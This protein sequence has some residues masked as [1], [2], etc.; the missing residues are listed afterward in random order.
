MSALQNRAPDPQGPIV[1]VALALI[2]FTATVA[3]VVLMRELMVVFHG[4]ELSL[5]LMLA[6]WLVWTAAGSGLLGKLRQGTKQPTRLVAALEA[7]LSV[8]FPS[9]VA[10]TRFSRQVFQ[11]VTG[12]MLGPAQMMAAAF[13][14]LA[15]FCLLSGWLFAAGSRMRMQVAGEDRA[16][17][18]SRVYLLEAAGSAAGGLAASLALIRWLDSL[19]V[20]WLLAALNLLVAARLAFGRSLVLVAAGLLLAPAWIGTRILETVSLRALWRGLTVLETRNSVYGNLTVVETEGGRTLYET[21][22]AAGTVPD[23]AAAEEAVHYA[24][25]QHPWPRR[26]LLLGGGWQGALG[27]ALKHPSIERVDYVELDP[28]VLEVAQRH[29]TAEWLAARCDPRVRVHSLD[30]RMY[31]RRNRDRY[32][33][34]IVNLPEPET[35]QLNRFYTLE[36]FREAAGRLDAQGVFSLRLR[37]AEN[38]LSPEL[39]R[40]LA[41]VHASLREVFAEVAMLPGETVH[42]FA[43]T[44]AG[45]LVRDAGALEE[46]LRTRG[47]QPRY[48]REYYFRFRLTPARVQMLEEQMRAAGPPRLNRDFAPVGYYYGVTRWSAQFDRRYRTALEMA[49]RAGFA[50]VAVSLSLAGALIAWGA[51]RRG[52]R[53]AAAVAVAAMGFT[54]MALQVLLLVGFQVLFGY[55]YHQLALIVGAFMAGMALGSRQA[56][57]HPGER[58]VALLALLAGLASASGLALFAL[59]RLLSG[60]SAGSAVWLAGHV[61]VPLLAAACGWMGGLQFP[62][63]SRLYFREG[64][65]SAPGGLYALDLAG[66][67]A[68]ALLTS[69]YLLPVFG[70]FKTA[71]LLAL[72]NL[73]GAVLAGRFAARR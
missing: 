66:A 33:V 43:A 52:E 73:P 46:R 56:L 30:G 23:P 45:L 58:D 18:S 4:N 3:Q 28:A 69:G 51:A 16:A 25:L 63:A 34:V 12:E 64:L 22:L 57:A 26:L 67:C 60:A 50:P 27:E 49:A 38:Y 48:V 62:V 21:G 15:P 14:V 6:S 41:S 29:F 71:C 20:A 47:I 19:A 8:A 54:L 70:Y 13:A 42:F 32:D 44:R 59:L 9:S 35:A 68:G 5:G 1:A 65:R 37:A 36:F 7:A 11:P 55:V 40:L 24:L 31:V 53:G 17:A 39:A 2:G 10:A 61:A 72:V